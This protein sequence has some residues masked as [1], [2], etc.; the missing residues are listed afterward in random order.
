MHKQITVTVNGVERT[1]EVPIR[2]LL[3]DFIRDTLQLTGTHQGC[4]FEGVCGA[5]TIQLNGEAV[6]SCMMLAVQADGQGITT[7]EGVAEAGQLH[8]VQKAFREHHG[9]Q[10]GYC[11]S[12]MIMN[13]I[14]FLRVNPSPTEAEVRHALIGNICRCTG[15]QNIV[16]AVRSAAAELSG[17]G[18]GTAQSQAAGK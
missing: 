5:C 7:I 11:T 18:S 14:E 9:L 6:K 2:M 1:H 16:E 13:A 17:A 3:V 8:P 4:T 15:Y 12:G 10:C